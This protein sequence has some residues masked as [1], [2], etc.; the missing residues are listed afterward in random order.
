MS[1]GR[2]GKVEVIPHAREHCD[3]VQGG[4]HGD[5]VDQVDQVDQRVDDLE[6]RRQTAT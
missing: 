5:Q 4:V 3:A 2:V 6:R 1:G